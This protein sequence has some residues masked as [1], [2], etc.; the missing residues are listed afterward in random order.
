MFQELKSGMERYSF[1]AFRSYR[2]R[3]LRVNVALTILCLTRIS[4]LCMSTN[5]PNQ[6]I[7]CSTVNPSTRKIIIK[8]FGPIFYVLNRSFYDT[9]FK[10]GMYMMFYVKESTWLVDTMFHHLLKYCAFHIF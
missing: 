10:W 3:V 5:K 4:L 8:T 1:T 7:M 2:L 6:F 9:F